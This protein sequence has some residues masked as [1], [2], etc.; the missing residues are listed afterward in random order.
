MALQNHSRERVR[1][2]RLLLSRTSPAEL[3]ERVFDVAIHLLICE[4]ARII[5]EHGNSEVA[6]FA[7]VKLGERRRGPGAPAP[8]IALASSRRAA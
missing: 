7:Y 4:L 5:L 8:V 3:R 1:I 2:G 6:P